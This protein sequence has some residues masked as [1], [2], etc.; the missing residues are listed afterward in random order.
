MSAAAIVMPRTQHFTA[1]LPGCQLSW[2][3]SFLY[4]NIFSEPQLGT[5]QMSHLGL[6][7]HSHFSARGT[8]MSL[9]V[10]RCPLHKD[11]LLTKV[12]S[13]TNLFL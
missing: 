10:N 13:S 4:C 9:C 8:V 7:T 3:F 5:L 1:L 2:V 12:K 11:A 6:S